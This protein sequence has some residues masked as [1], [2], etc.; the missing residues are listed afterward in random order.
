MS[1]TNPFRFLTLIF[2]ILLICCHSYGQQKD[3]YTA[4]IDS[5]IQTTSPRSFNGVI[6]ITQNGKTK[7]SKAF[8]YSDFENKIPL[9]IKDKFRIQSNSK[10]IT[11]VLILR[12]ADK[13]KIDLQSPIKKYLPEIK[14]AWADSV[15]VHQLLNF[16]SGITAIDKPLSFKPGTDFLYNVV[17]YTLLGNIIE[18]V[19]GKKYVAAANDLFKELDMNNSFCYEENKMQNRLVN[20]YTSSN[21]IFKLRAHPIQREDWVGFIPAGGIVSNLEDLNRWDTKLHNGAI[22]KPTTYKLMTNYT[23][24][25]Q[26]EAFGKEK[27]GYGYGVYISDKTPLKY[28][29]HPGKGLGF[30]SL[31]IY[32]PEINVDLIVLENQYSDDESLHYY[33][34]KEIRKIV[35]SSNLMEQ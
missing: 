22:L 21:N 15:T 28:I 23:I 11:A 7:Y 14:Q 12:E 18:Q 25:A 33:F 4:K 27:I 3:D 19:T 24:T 6:L 13:G 35:M 20:G 32:F 9:A 31:K 1:I 26:H 34:E 10:Q 5:L 30:V 29:G 8:G 16:S 17:A 2:S